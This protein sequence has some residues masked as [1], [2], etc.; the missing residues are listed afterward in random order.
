VEDVEFVEDVLEIDEANVPGAVLLFDE[1][2][3]CGGGGAVAPSG[4]K[5]YEIDGWSLC[6]LVN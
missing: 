1:R 4:I 3:E 5:E 2:L 6:H